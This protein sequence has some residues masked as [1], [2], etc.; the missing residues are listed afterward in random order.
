[1]KPVRS[2]KGVYEVALAKNGRATCRYGTERRAGKRHIVSLEIG[3]HEILE[4]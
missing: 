2:R 3:G 4:R 1:V